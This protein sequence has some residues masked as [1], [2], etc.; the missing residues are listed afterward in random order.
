MFVTKILV[1][2]RQDNEPHGR[3]SYSQTSIP[4]WRAQIQTHKKL[5]SLR[6]KSNS[7]KKSNSRASSEAN[8]SQFWREINRVG[9]LGFE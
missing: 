9:E 6:K 5:N 7:L 4:R 8:M 1:W 3:E 2:S